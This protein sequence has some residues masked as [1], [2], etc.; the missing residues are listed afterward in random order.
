[1]RLTPREEAVMVCYIAIY[2]N[3]DTQEIAGI[4]KKYGS[5]TSRIVYRGQAK[6]DTTIDNR[7]PFV[8]TSPSRE[9]AEQFVEHDWEANKKV[10]NLFTI[11]LE[12]AKWL[13][14]RSI[15]FTLTDEVKEEL[16][17]INS[18]P[19]QKERDYTLDE[20]WPQ[21]KTRLTELLAEG[22]EILVL[23]GDTLNTTRYSV[24]GRK[25]RKTKKSKR[26]VRKTRRRHK[27]N[28]IK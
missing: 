3:C 4:I 24:G 9:M 11:H 27:K 10:G 13:S 7:K 2:Y 12:N 20:F 6:Q 26:R 18:K 28:Y 15:E 23:T 8:S 22:E 17:K 16:R 5:T 21:I 19:I 1:M 25:T 14:T